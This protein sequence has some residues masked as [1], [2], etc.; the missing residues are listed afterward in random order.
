VGKECLLWYEE[1]MR[2]FVL[3]MDKRQVQQ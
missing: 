2:L 3:L 1:W